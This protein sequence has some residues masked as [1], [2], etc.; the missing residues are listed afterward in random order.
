MDSYRL[1]L[2]IHTLSFTGHL[3]HYDDVL[4][5][6]PENIGTQRLEI[7]KLGADANEVTV[8]VVIGVIERCGVNLVYKGFF[9]RG[10]VGVCG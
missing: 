5:T 6:E 7:V 4:L 1:D 9:E 2:D 8:A 3:G 10:T